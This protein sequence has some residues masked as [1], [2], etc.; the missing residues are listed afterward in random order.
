MC[1]FGGG[2]FGKGLGHKH[3]ALRNGTGA[4]IKAAGE[5]SLCPPAMWGHSQGTAC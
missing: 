4:L 2:A 1:G 3:R 5:V